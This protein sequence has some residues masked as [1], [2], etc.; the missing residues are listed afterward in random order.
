MFVLFA[1]LLALCDLGCVRSECFVLVCSVSVVGLFAPLA[2][3]LS[4]VRCV[5]LSCAGCNGLL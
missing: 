5:V 1:Y 2:L 4:F 3:I